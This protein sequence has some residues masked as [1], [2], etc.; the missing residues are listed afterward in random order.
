MQSVTFAFIMV[1]EYFP[2][3]SFRTNKCTL[4]VLDT[5]FQIN[6]RWIMH[7]HKCLNYLQNISSLLSMP[8]KCLAEQCKY[9]R[10]LLSRIKYC[11]ET[12]WSKQTLPCR[13]HF[14]FSEEH[15]ALGEMLCDF[16]KQECF[17]ELIQSF[18]AGMANDSPRVCRSIAQ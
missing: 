4:E 14:H 1:L 17:T 8:S 5:M 12:L 2:I 18:H 6:R 16:H 10:S 3:S 15:S 11:C 7:E 9:K 13:S